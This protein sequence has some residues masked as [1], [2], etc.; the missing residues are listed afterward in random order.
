MYMEMYAYMCMYT[1]MSVYMSMYMFVGSANG[2]SLGVLLL[3]TAR[4]V[5]SASGRFQFSVYLYCCYLWK[6]KVV[7]AGRAQRSTFG[8]PHGVFSLSPL[9]PRPQDVHSVA[10]HRETVVRL[11]RRA[12]PYLHPPPLARAA[13][14]PR[15]VVGGRPA[16][17]SR[18]KGGHE[19]PVRLRH[20][21]ACAQRRGMDHCHGQA[22]RSQ[23]PIFRTSGNMVRL[24]VAF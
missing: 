11:E 6:N 24:S 17:D 5:G 13:C 10:L 8:V 18:C 19:P 12:T 20:A 2:L 21:P 1:R 3:G 22:P 15:L 14:P 7:C 9:P 23:Q 16:I 4:L